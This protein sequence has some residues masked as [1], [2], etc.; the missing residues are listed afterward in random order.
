MYEEGPKAGWPQKEPEG[1]FSPNLGNF[2]ENFREIL[3]E[4][5]KLCNKFGVWGIFQIWKNNIRTLFG[6][7]FSVKKIILEI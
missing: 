3:K 4:S 7:K 2:T 6:R 1:T 5:E